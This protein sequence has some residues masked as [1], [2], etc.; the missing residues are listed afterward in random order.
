MGAPRSRASAGKRC[1]VSC[2]AAGAPLNPLPLRGAGFSAAGRREAAVSPA[3]VFPPAP[4]FRRHPLFM[5]II[6]RGENPSPF[7]RLRSLAG[8]NRTAAIFVF[9]A[10]A[11]RVPPPEIPRRS[12]NAP[13]PRESPCGCG[14]R[15]LVGN[16]SGVCFDRAFCGMLQAKAMW[17]ACARPP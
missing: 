8:G 10:A 13:R 12:L 17:A 5:R 9:C 4:P 11:L 3:L 2:G 6:G 14:A 15:G 7:G 1:H 16:S